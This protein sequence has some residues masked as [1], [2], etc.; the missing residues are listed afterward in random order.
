MLILAISSPGVL[1]TTMEI[2][3]IFEP[4]L[5]VPQQF[6]LVLTFYLSVALVIADVLVGLSYL[7]RDRLQ[8]T[9]QRVNVDM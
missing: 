8:K 3:V 9:A 7:I 4:V 5:I 6:R 1:L 2:G